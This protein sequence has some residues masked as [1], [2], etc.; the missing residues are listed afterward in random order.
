MV[1]F[2]SFY[3]TSMWV[4]DDRVNEYLEAGYKL[5]S[6]DSEKPVEEEKPKK[7]TTKKK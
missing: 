1:E 3:G 6:E 2:K 5:A 4:T 7:K